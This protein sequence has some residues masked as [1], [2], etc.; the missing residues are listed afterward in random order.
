MGLGLFYS[1]GIG[2]FSYQ[3]H[4]DVAPLCGKEKAAYTSLSNRRAHVFI[5]YV[6]NVGTCLWPPLSVLN[7][8]TQHFGGAMVA[9]DNAH[10]C[11]RNAARGCNNRHNPR[12][13]TV[14]QSGFSNA[15]RVACVR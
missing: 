6:Y 5:F 7:I 4:G 15:E 1:R 9:I 2:G 10:V 12:V 11:D 13:G 14:L 3:L 8:H